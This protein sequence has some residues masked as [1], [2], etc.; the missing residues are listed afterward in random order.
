MQDASD[1]AA[2]L[3]IGQRVR[4]GLDDEYSKWQD[5]MNKAAAGYPGFI[6]AEIR[7]PSAGMP[8]WLALAQF[9]SVAH[10]RNWLNSAT[11]Q[12]FLDEG[13][14]LFDGP[15]TQQVIARGRS[16]E[17]TLVTVVVTHRVAPGR[18]DDFLTWQ[19]NIKEIESKYAGFRGSEVFRPIEGVQDEWTIAYRFD[20]AAN[21]EAWLTSADRKNLLADNN[22]GDFNLRKIDHSFGNWFAFKDDPGAPPPSDFKTSLAVWMGLYPTVV[23][24]TLMTSPLHMPLWL[25]MLVGNF[26]SS[27]VMSY[28]TMPYYANPLVGWWLKP[29]AVARQP[30]TDWRGFALIVG[31]NVVWAVIFYLVTVTFWT[32]P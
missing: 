27:F 29:N 30:G 3:I 4:P 2:T 9:N 18:V 5:E 26:L 12:R 23:F 32:L 28:V 11:R 1:G 25:G 21:L 15:G 6:G 31:I 7:P 14:A 13:R 17:D 20:S 19:K 16:E 22:F 24:L 8:D 10:A